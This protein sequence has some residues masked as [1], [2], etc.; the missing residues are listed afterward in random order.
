MADHPSDARGTSSTPNIGCLLKECGAKSDEG[1]SDDTTSVE[2]DSHNKMRRARVQPKCMTRLLPNSWR[3][4][5]F[6]L[7]FSD[8]ILSRNF[9]FFY[10]SAPFSCAT[11]YNKLA[12]SPWQKVSHERRP[13]GIRTD[14]VTLEIRRFDQL[15]IEHQ[16][17]GSEYS[18]FG[19]SIACLAPQYFKLHNLDA[20]RVQSSIYI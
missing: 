11:S 13:N 5:N 10:S 14:V 3:S 18:P 6:S 19:S 8:S 16:E 1:H 12:P 9:I 20:L 17:P 2:S 15:H 4:C 7:T